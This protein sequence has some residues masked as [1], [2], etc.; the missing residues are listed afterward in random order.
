[1]TLVLLRWW[2]HW[3]LSLA[4]K[5]ERETEDLCMGLLYTPPEPTASLLWT[6][7]SDQIQRI[8]VLTANLYLV[9]L[10]CAQNFFHNYVVKIMFFLADYLVWNRYYLE[11]SPFISFTLLC[12]FKMKQV[13]ILWTIT[14]LS[15]LPTILFRG[16]VR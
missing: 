12:H 9:I 7:C 16:R 6:L 13:S 5:P 14:W 15:L 3:T 11:V 10:K 2:N 1:M 8:E 4:T